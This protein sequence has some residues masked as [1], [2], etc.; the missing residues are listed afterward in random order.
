MKVM[1]KMSMKALRRNAQPQ[2]LMILTMIIVIIIII[3]VTMMRMLILVVRL[4]LH[5]IQNMMKTIL[6]LKNPI[7]I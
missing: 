1:M 4:H 7:F 5:T 6:K 2:S 3:I